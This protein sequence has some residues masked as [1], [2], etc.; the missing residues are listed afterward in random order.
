MFYISIFLFIISL[1]IFIFRKRLSDEIETSPIVISSVIF[2]IGLILF[3][4]SSFVKIGAGQVGVTSLFGNVDNNVLHSGLNIVNPLKSVEKMNIQL[5]EYTM[6][7]QSKDNDDEYNHDE[8][9][10]TLTSDGLTVT[11]EVTV[12]YKINESEAP[13]IYKNIGVDYENSVVRPSVRSTFRDISVGYPAIEIYSTKREEFVSKISIQLIS[14]LK[15]KGINLEKV[16]LRDVRLPDKVREAI[17]SKI[18]ME[19][20]SQKMVYVLQKERQEAERK[21]I[22][23]KGINT[24]QTIVSSGISEQLLKW[25]AIEVAEKLVYSNNSKIIMLGDKSGLPIMLSDK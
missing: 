10:S 11:M 18:A 25:K 3:I 5:Q 13:I 2:V 8:A 6:T 20:E 1:V 15:D 7:H 21:E 14:L 19:Q 17:D 16:L 22:E 9:M 23:A 12:W 4:F 24:F